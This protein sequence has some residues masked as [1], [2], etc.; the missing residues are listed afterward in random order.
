MANGN[1]KK[2]ELKL[3]RT[4]IIILVAGMTALLCSVFMLGIQVGKNIDTY[5]EKIASIPQKA[6]ALV[7]RKAKTDATPDIVD[8]KTGQGEPKAGESIDLTFY[9]DLTS[10][11]GVGKDSPLLEKKMVETP[12]P[13][14]KGEEKETI[15]GKGLETP[16]LPVAVNEK[17]GDKKKHEVKEVEA[18]AAAVA[19][20]KQVFIIQAASLKEKAKAYQMIKNLS[21]MGYKSHVVKIDIKGKG[22]WFRVIV[23]GFDERARAQ[24][25]ADKIAKKMK[26]KCI[27]RRDD[28]DTK[29]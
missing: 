6:L 22:T 29:K 21:D 25:A 14:S 18:P 28:A 13:Q 27:I 4:G 2:M 5:P 20:S 26:T 11:K 17:A 23:S 16:K 1:I 9:N 8:N 19:A 3:G 10:K 7:W 24:A 15:A 12:P